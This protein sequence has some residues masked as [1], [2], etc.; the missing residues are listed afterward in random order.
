SDAGGWP[1]ID[2]NAGRLHPG[3]VADFKSE[4]PAGLNRNPQVAGEF[5]DL[6]KSL[7]SRGHQPETVAHFINRLV[8]CMFA[9]DVKLLPARCS[10]G[11]PRLS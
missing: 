7:R 8:F 1:V 5:A 2:R 10:R 3:M 9:E 4:Y 11:C 6:A